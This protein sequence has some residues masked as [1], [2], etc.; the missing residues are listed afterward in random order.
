MSNTRTFTPG[1]GTGITEATSASSGANTVKAN[2]T[3][4]VLTNLGTVTV[5]VR[6]GAAAVAATVADYPVLSGTQVSVNKPAEHTHIS[7]ISPDGAGSLH[8]IAGAGF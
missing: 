7:H 2:S 5:Y 3:S 8:Y 1:Y 6:I 4:V